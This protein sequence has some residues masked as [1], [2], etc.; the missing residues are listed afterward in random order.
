MGAA[1]GWARDE[2]SLTW[3][4]L[5]VFAHNRVARALYDSLG[6]AATATVPDLFRIHGRSID[7]V[8]MGLGL[9]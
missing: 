4:D 2:P 6:F 1:L 9:R 5:G 7:D 3:V 8:R